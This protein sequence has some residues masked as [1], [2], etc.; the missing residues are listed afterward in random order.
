MPAYKPQLNGP[1]TLTSIPLSKALGTPIAPLTGV[2]SA[3]NQTF[4]AGTSGDNAVHLIIK[5]DECAQRIL[6]GYIVAG[7]QQRLCLCP[8]DAG[9]T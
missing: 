3:D 8:E 7:V 5:I 4:Y 1:G 6:V 2:V 9:E